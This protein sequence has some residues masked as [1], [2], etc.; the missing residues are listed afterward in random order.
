MTIRDQSGVS[1]DW[2]TGYEAEALGEDHVMFIAMSKPS[3]TKKA[4]QV[5]DRAPQ[6]RM[7]TQSVV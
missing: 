4:I 6:H 7:Q 1:E 2:L 3:E 5:S